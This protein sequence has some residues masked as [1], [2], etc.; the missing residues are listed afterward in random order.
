MSTIEFYPGVVTVNSVAT[1]Q[2]IGC[3]WMK[4]TFTT[5]KSMPRCE[6]SPARVP[7]IAQPPHPNTLTIAFAYGVADKIDS[8]TIEGS[9]KACLCGLCSCNCCWK[10]VASLTL[11]MERD[12]QAGLCASLL[13]MEDDNQISIL[14]N[15]SQVNTD[16]VLGYVYG[17]QA[18]EPGFLA[19]VGGPANP[20]PAIEMER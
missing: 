14:V 9:D 3:C 19:K 6:F 4:Y 1:L 8:A 2:Q 12:A 20:R 11:T 10:P 16:I 5:S 18:S 7:A 13:G 17:G 15:A